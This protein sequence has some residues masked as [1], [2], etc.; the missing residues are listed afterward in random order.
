MSESLN[1]EEIEDLIEGLDKDC[2]QL[3]A[4][5]NKHLFFPIRKAQDDLQKKLYNIGWKIQKLQKHIYRM[6]E[7]EKK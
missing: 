2:S 6:K 7:E 1:K 5:E 3:F 4:S